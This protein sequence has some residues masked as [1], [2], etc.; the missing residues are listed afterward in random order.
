[1]RTESTTFPASRLGGVIV[2]VIA[3]GLNVRGFKPGQD[4]FLK[5]IQICSMHFFAG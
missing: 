1:V 3:I 4:G 2:S 5:V